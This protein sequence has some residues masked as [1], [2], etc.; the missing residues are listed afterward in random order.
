MDTT[1]TQDDASSHSVTLAD[2]AAATGTLVD[3][4]KTPSNIGRLHIKTSAD[5]TDREQML[6]AGFLEGYLSA[7]I[8]APC[9]LLARQH[10]VMKS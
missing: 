3:A 5:Y 1:C 10:K 8:A 2:V 7:G 4:A 9:L 6:A